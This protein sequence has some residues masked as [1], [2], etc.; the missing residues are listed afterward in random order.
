[1][2]EPDAS[3]KRWGLTDA[4]VGLVVSIVFAGLVGGI[5]ITARGDYTGKWS[6]HGAA[7][8]RI[9]AQAA[10]DG[11]LSAPQLTPLWLITILQVPLWA[12]L[13]GT[14]IFAAK[15]GGGIVA[16]FG[17]RMKASDIIVGLFVGFLA[18][19]VVIPLVYWP[20]LKLLGEPDVSAEARSLTDRAHG[21]G[22]VLLVLLTVVG[23]PIVEELF[24]RGLLMRSFERRVR[25]VWAV[26]ATA[27]L[28]ALAHFQPLQFLALVIFG[29]I[30]GTL[31]HRA[32]RLG[33]SIWAHVAFNATTVIALLAR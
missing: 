20:L 31:A 11:R 10:G 17:L 7:A 6:E 3:A 27:V 9:A 16:D 24:F 23:A 13:L 29:A 14:V 2:G 18:Q 15:K 12:G 1:M 21:I 5:V 28:F 19:V 26:G 25:P 32:G 4:L 8:G 22:V 30:A 33:P